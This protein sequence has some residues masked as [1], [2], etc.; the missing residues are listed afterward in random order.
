[1]IPLNGA[2]LTCMCHFPNSPPGH[3][4]K[5]PIPA[6]WGL[7][8]DYITQNSQSWAAAMLPNES[9]ERGARVTW[10][11]N[12]LLPPLGGHVSCSGFCLTGVKGWGILGQSWGDGI[13]EVRERVSVPAAQRRVSG[14]TPPPGV[15]H[16][17][18]RI[19][20][21]APVYSLLSWL[22]SAPRV[23]WQR[24]RQRRRTRFR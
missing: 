20:I 15:P 11:R 24:Q 16:P 1:M 3:L 17:R 10:G 6:L 18:P 19:G 23:R 4:H 7:Y 8:G 2:K 13:E 5:K 21:A 14:S 22:R 12:F 9:L